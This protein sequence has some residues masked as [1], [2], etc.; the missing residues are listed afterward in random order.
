VTSSHCSFLSIHLKHSASREALQDSSRSPRRRAGSG[1]TINRPD[2]ISAISLSD[3]NRNLNFN[4]ALGPAVH[5]F[6]LFRLWSNSH[7]S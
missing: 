7:A 6:P 3:R 5:F 4:P 2:L 1:N